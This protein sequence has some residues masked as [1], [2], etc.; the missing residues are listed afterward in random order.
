MKLQK[1]KLIGELR[2]RKKTEQNFFNQIIV[3]FGIILFKFLCMI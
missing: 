2:R 1:L 3:N